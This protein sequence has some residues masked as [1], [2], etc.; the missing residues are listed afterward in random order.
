[1]SHDAFG[2]VFADLQEHAHLFVCVVRRV[3][4]WT[5]HSAIGCDPKIDPATVRMPIR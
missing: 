4:R 2:D 5:L 1:L 3:G